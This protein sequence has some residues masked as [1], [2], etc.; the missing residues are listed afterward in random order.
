LVYLS[1]TNHLYPADF[2]MKIK[3]HRVM[4]PV[5]RLSMAAPAHL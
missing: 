2:N 3:H 4:Y 1:H 5:F